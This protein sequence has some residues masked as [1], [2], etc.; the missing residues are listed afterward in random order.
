MVTKSSPNDNSVLRRIYAAICHERLRETSPEPKQ[1]QAHYTI[2]DLL[3]QYSHDSCFIFHL[4]KLFP[5]IFVHSLFMIK[6]EIGFA[7][8]DS[9]IDRNKYS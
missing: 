5:W 4:I 8:A 7:S 3:D 6:S 1:R 2:G 9:F